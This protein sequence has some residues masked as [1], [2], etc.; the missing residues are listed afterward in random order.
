MWDRHLKRPVNSMISRSLTASK[1][2]L[3]KIHWLNPGRLPDPVCLEHRASLSFWAKVLMVWTWISHLLRN[4]MP[5][6]GCCKDKEGNTLGIFSLHGVS[7][8]TQE[9]ERIYII[10]SPLRLLVG[11]KIHSVGVIQR[12]GKDCYVKAVLLS[13]LLLSS[14][15]NASRWKYVPVTF[16]S[17]I[18][19]PTG[20]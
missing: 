4:I 1:T 12:A 8:S 18:P 20:N 6:Y 10:S 15:K 19:S 9:P 7:R 3:A 11:R 13:L 16:F 2:Q 5:G 17:C 14:Q